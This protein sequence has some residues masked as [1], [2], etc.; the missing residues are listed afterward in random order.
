MTDAMRVHEAKTRH[1]GHRK[2]SKAETDH[3]REE[4]EREKKSS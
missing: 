3:K 4:G 1:D 2:L